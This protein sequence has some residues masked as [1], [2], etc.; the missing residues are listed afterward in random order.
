LSRGGGE[1]VPQAVRTPGPF[2]FGEKL[3][4][5]HY[6]EGAAVVRILR[7]LVACAPNRDGEA[8]RDPTQGERRDSSAVSL[9]KVHAQGRTPRNG[10]V[11][12]RSGLHQYRHRE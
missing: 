12:E 9:R 1:Q 7:H 3:C 10:M 6:A 5:R 4:R 11:H 8:Q 2:F